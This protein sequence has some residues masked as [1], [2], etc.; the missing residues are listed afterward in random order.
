MY[1]RIRVHVTES[2]R[3]ARLVIYDF[4]DKRICAVGTE[5]E[6]EYTDI[7]NAVRQIHPKVVRDIDGRGDIYIR[8][9][10]FPDGKVSV[11]ASLRRL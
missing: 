7:L 4:T 11:I 8:L 5:T 3:T 2:I 9:D 1:D 10:R 6:N